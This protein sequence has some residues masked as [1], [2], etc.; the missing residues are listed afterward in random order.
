MLSDYGGVRKI[1]W[2]QIG[3]RDVRKEKLDRIKATD[4]TGMEL[5]PPGNPDTDNDNCHAIY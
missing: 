4:C 3:K 5:K 1:T 2:D